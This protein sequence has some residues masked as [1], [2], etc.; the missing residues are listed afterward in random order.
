[1][2]ISVTII[3]RNPIHTT[4]R[5]FVNGGLSGKLI[6]RNEEYEEFIT[7][8]KPDRIRDET[9]QKR[10][11]LIYYTPPS[12]ESF[13]DLKSNAISLWS[14][15]GDEESYRREKI[16]RIKNLQNVKDNF[17]YIFA[18][19]DSVNQVRLVSRLKGKTLDDLNERLVDGG[20]NFTFE[21]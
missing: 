3:E 6:L 15:L 8:I 10:S 16:D 13:N 20:N 12:D 21:V 11:I 9:M 17:M 1:M 19:F 4:F 14:T 18:M 7:R 5:V 2:K